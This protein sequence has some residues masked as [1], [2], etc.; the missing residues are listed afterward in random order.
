[1]T[2]TGSDAGS[3]P[4]LNEVPLPARLRADTGLDRIDYSDAHLVEAVAASSEISPE[5]WAREVLECAP[6]ALRRMLP[7]GWFLL[8]LRQGS[9][10]SSQH[11]LGWPIRENTAERIVL[12]SQSRLG[13]PAELVFAREG[14]AWLFAT[15]VQHDNAVMSTLW[16]AIAKSHRRIVRYLLR[17]AAARVTD[18]SNRP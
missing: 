14:D 10:R 3:T 1:M 5:Q 8:G 15:L 2:Q 9:S 7:P 16:R 4:V 17:S 18:V 13:M 12:T 6:S 11:V